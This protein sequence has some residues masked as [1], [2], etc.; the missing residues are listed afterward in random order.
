MHDLAA[1]MHDLA[2]AMRGLTAAIKAHPPYP[3]VY[4]A[5]PYAPALPWWETQPVVTS[6]TTQE[7]RPP[8]DTVSVTCEMPSASAISYAL[9]AYTRCEGRMR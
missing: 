5:A 3:Y 4:P 7:T 9:T 8:T 1:A 2:A 6:D